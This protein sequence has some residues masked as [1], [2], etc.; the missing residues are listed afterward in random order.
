LGQITASRETEQGLQKGIQ[1]TRSDKE[2]FT[3]PSR[4]IQ[5]AGASNVSAVQELGSA[6]ASE[7]GKIRDELRR[8]PQQIK[9]GQI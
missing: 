3:D 5:E 8:L 4:S 7:L 6:M 9:A 1:T 2:G